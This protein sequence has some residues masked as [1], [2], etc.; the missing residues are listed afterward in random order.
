MPSSN[1]WLTLASISAARQGCAIRWAVED[2]L[3]AALIEHR[4]RR[5]VRPGSAAVDVQ[6]DVIDLQAVR[7]LD[8]NEASE[9]VSAHRAPAAQRHAAW[10]WPVIPS[11]GRDSIPR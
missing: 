9:G 4:S 3:P 5:Q 7:Q 10:R 8:I 6:S 2:G 1:A 11:G